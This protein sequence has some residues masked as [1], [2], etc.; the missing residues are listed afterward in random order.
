MTAAEGVKFSGT[1]NI[2]NLQQWEGMNFL[3][4]ISVKKA[5]SENHRK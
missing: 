2:V 1:K 4:E 5:L 3:Y